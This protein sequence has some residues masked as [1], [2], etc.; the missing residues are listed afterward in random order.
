MDINERNLRG[1]VNYERT[2][3][4]LERNLNIK[5]SELENHQK[6]I[7]E[8]EVTVQLRT[9]ELAVMAKC[10]EESHEFACNLYEAKRNEWKQ[11]LLDLKKVINNLELRVENEL[12]EGNLRII[13]GLN[14]LH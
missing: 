3:K 14:V 13:N 1:L 12:I 9:N 8:L 6:K 2:Y 10:W 4:K 7:T 11:K 5:T